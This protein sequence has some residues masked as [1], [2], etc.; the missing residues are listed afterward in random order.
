MTRRERVLRTLNFEDYSALDMGGMLSTGISCFAYPGL[1]N[2]LGLPS[3]LPRVHD[4]IQMLALPDI[5]VLDA[6]DCDIA[7]V[8]LDEWTNAYR[9]DN[10]TW[11][12]YA[13]NGRIQALVQNPDNFEA[14]GDGSVEYRNEKGSY[15]MVP[16]SYVFD[17]DH[18]GEPFNIFQL[19]P[20]KETI[21]SVK[22]Q[23]EAAKLSDEKIVSIREYCKKARNS[24]DRAILF[25][26][27]PMG[28]KYRNGM[29][30][31]SMFC[32]TD[33]DYVE[34][35]H[36]CITDYWLDNAKR[37]LPE[38]SSYIDIFM[39]NSDDQGTQNSTIL[40]PKIYNQL[41]VPYYKLMN[42]EIHHS[43]PNLK[44]FLHSC[45]AI[46][47]L[48]DSIIEAGF[49]IINPV[50]WSAGNHSYREWK[51]LCRKRIV[52][53]GGGINSQST[54]PFGNLHEIELETKEI[55]SYLK[56]D[57]GYIFTAIH[58]ILAEISP[59]KI[60]TLYNAAK[61]ELQ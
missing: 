61:Q 20:K 41:Y 8:H 13:F 38:I 2:T 45:G 47:P 29:A 19:E 43:A 55:C 16:S 26:G 14:V 46:F 42:N 33:P 28:L 50:Q 12:P 1:V 52:L 5:D 9:E 54:L 6:L 3:R 21:E 58:N 4:P 31:W 48:L 57:G 18:G 40:P 59:E 15:K 51:D 17:A 23:L 56:K 35:I 27:L 30:E 34:E 44:S 7:T 49:D 11:K 60:I 39:A 10:S 37:L 53:W 22:I 36:S 24:T 32:L 25:N